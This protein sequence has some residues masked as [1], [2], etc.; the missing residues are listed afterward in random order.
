MARR[1]AVPLDQRPG[2]PF[3][4]TEFNVSTAPSA[5]RSRSAAHSI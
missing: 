5:L 2:G 4:R 3:L 1:I